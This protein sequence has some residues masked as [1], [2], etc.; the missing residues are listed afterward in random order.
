VTGIA[1]GAKKSKRRFVNKLEEFSLLHFFYRPPRGTAGLFILSEAEL[2]AAHLSL[3]TSFQRY[4]S[5]M[6]LCELVLRFT[7]DNDPD[8]R[9]Y[10]VLKWALSALHQEKAPQKIT[11]LAHLRLLDVV[12]YR[13]EL[14]HCTCCRQTVGPTRTYMFLPEAGVVLCST[15]SMGKGNRSHCLSLQTL[16]LLANAQTFELERLHRLHFTQQALTEALPALHHFTLHL[17]QQDVHSWNILRSFTSAPTP[18]PGL[19][20]PGTFPP[21]F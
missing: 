1:K 18:P 17:L 10:S 12:G 5:A 14:S 8:P 11:L 21:R 19:S 16:R 15:C 4:A 20:G 13:P 7:R 2:L 3:R 6:Y 9:I